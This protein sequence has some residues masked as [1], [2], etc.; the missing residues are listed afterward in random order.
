MAGRLS[1]PTFYQNF[2]PV[3]RR[4]TVWTR[5]WSP[6]KPP[7]NVVQKKCGEN[8]LDSSEL[9]N[10]TFPRIFA[11]KGGYKDNKS[12]S[13]K[14]NSNIYENQLRSDRTLREIRFI[15]LKTLICMFL[16]LPCPVHKDEPDFSAFLFVFVLLT[17]VFLLYKSLKLGFIDHVRFNCSYIS[18][19]SI[20]TVPIGTYVYYSLE[21]KQENFYFAIGSFYITI[22]SLR[23]VR[24]PI[25]YWIPYSSARSLQISYL[26][27]SINVFIYFFVLL[28]NA[29][30]DG[31][32]FSNC[33]FWMDIR[34]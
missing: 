13:Y 30:R 20:G 28:K 5:N 2:N 23:P 34:H 16:Q 14:N 9:Q 10:L 15:A 32:Q 31:D 26:F 8:S 11:G 29:H 21:R 19:T 27:S 25:T 6:C 7:T 3:F 1:R 4:R 22:I 18:S 33:S 17:R 12:G 24:I